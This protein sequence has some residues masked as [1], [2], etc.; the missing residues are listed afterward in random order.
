M[1]LLNQTVGLMVEPSYCS[2]HGFNLP[3]PGSCDQFVDDSMHCE[4]PYF[5]MQLAMQIGHGSWGCTHDSIMLVP[6]HDGSISKC[7]NQS[8]RTAFG[9]TMYLAD[10]CNT[11]M[12]N[13]CQLIC[14]T[15]VMY[16]AHKKTQAPLLNSTWSES[17]TIKQAKTMAVKL[18][19]NYM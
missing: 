12:G 13:H 17:T 6:Y 8:V 18:T 19:N 5:Y 11:D 14:T 4:L 3:V 7:C 16:I 1:Q 10:V 9:Y 2:T 15:S